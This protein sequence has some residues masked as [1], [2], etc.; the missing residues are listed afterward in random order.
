LI[1]DTLTDNSSWF[2]IIGLVRLGAGTIIGLMC[3]GDYIA[4]S[5]IRC[6][7]GVESILD[8]IYSVSNH[9]LS[10]FSSNDNSNPP[11]PPVNIPE[12]ISRSSSGSSTI[13]PP[14]P[15][16]SRSSTSMPDEILNNW[17]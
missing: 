9:V 12:V 5:L 13:T 11:K 1:K 14:T 2:S 10:W 4:P 6:I 17:D 7:P 3:V 15:P 8:S 16:I